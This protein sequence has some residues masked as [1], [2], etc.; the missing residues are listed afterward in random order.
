MNRVG[1]D[2]LWDDEDGFYYD[3]VH[4][5]D[6]TVPLRVRSLVGLVPLFA[7]E[8]LEDDAIERLPEFSKRMRWFLRNRRDLS[9]Q[10][11][12]VERSKQGDRLLAIPSARR[13]RRVLRYVF[14]E[15]EFL[16][17]YGIRSLSRAH[18][19][20][21]YRFGVGGSE[22]DVRYTP[23][24][25]DSN[26]FGGNSNWRGPIWLPMNFML[27]EALE[28]YH[29][30][31]GN[32]FEIE[33]PTGSANRLNLQEA[34][35]EIARRL[36]RIFIPNA[37]GVRP[38]HGASERYAEDPHWRDL[39]LFYEYF[40]GDTGLGLGASHQTGWT[41]LI[42]RLLEDLAGT[43]A[44]TSPSTVAGSAAGDRSTS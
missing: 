29:R 3:R 24:E 19:D 33:V 12:Y 7:V 14:D 15:S 20:N 36:T 8:V 18:L 16:S 37:D 42:V 6:A 43:R 35:R 34:A 38:C 13:L 26:L 4:K 27:V 1:G 21:P 17:S 9:G 11:T 40:N 5:D 28:R 2:G 23:G 39:V 22:F 30:F 41:A 32:S 44:A 10:V 31:Y 25:S